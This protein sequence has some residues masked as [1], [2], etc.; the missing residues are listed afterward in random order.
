M[1][2]TDTFY[3]QIKTI[4]RIIT[5]SVGKNYIYIYKSPS[6]I[7]WIPTTWD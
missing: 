4:Y 2:K 5:Y 6:N 7:N 3:T 1:N